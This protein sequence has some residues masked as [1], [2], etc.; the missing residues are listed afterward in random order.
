MSH[1]NISRRSF[2]KT[3]L[4]FLLAGRAGFR[5]DLAVTSAR[6]REVEVVLEARVANLARELV[7]FGLPLPPG[8]L[9]DP[10]NVRVTSEAGEEISAAVRSLEPWR[11]GGREGSIRS[12]LIQFT[13]DFS[14]DRNQRVK[15]LF[16]PRRKNE[17]GF[18]PVAETL[19]DKDFLVPSL[20]STAR[21]I[22]NGFLIGPP[23]TTRCLLARA[24]RNSWQR[25]IT[26]P[27][28]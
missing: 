11:I 24:I 28:S 6:K 22:P 25:H 14:R 12:L 2:V 8:F 5:S 21:F 19:I 26:Q 3:G 17:T 18:I 23:F 7:S 20:I 10:R 1:A 9:S 15:I 13:A 27:T 4:T 16:L